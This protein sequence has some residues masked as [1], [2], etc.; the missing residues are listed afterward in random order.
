MSRTFTDVWNDASKLSE[1]DRAVLAGL[2]IDSVEG[3][4]DADDEAAWT[5]E[6]ERRVSELDADAVN[7]IPWEEL[8]RR[9]L[10]RLNER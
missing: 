5:A 4:P 10:D 3:T 1:E 8:R 7:S 6:T 2:L 9:L